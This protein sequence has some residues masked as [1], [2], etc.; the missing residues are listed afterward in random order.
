MAMTK[1]SKTFKFKWNLFIVGLV[2]IVA[3]YV[4]L[5]AA[6]TTFAPILLVLGYCVL[7]PLSFL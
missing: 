5:A 7:V 1:A 3:G 6:D 2:A 4:L